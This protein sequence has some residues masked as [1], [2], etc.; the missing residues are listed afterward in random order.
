MMRLLRSFKS[1]LCLLALCG[2]GAFVNFDESPVG[3]F[4]GEA[5]VVWT[6]GGIESGEGD[7]EFLYVP[8]PGKELRFIRNTSAMIS[9][10]NDVIE[11]GPFYTDGGS[12]PRWVQ[13]LPGFNAWAFGPAYIIHDWLFVVKKC[14]NDEDAGALQ[15]PIS[16]MEFKESTAIMAETI[17][18][19]ASQ[20][21]FP[22][23][24]AGAGNAITLA[25]GSSISLSRWR[26]QGA[27]EQ[28]KVTNPKHVRIIED[29]QRPRK[30]KTKSRGFEVLRLPKP[31]DRVDDVPAYR[32]IS[33]IRF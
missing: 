22:E 10:G 4:E 13:A 18:T 15:N 9:A 24:I 20:Y 26:E 3:K 32:V 14:A 25:T 19:V 11:P 2:C 31:A 23:R 17:Q 16:Q 21:G 5:V 30:V 33:T 1:Y 28:Q 8:V 6:G 29:L 7:G 12:V 27:C